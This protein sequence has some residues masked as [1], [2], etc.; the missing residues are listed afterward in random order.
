MLLVVFAVWRG[1]TPDEVSPRFTS[2]KIDGILAP[3]TPEPDSAGK[4]R[5]PADGQ[6]IRK[7]VPLEAK[8]S[9]FKKQTPAMAHFRSGPQSY[10]T[11]NSHPTNVKEEKRAVSSSSPE[12]LYI[13]LATGDPD[14]LIVWLIDP[15]RGEK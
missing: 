1:H 8:K 12:P 11:S 4:G 3:V 6:E 15:D 5:R 9:R 14:V 13:E 7:A 2:K 10:R